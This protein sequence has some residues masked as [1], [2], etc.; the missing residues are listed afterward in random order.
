[1]Q[2]F[3][4]YL[5]LRYK[6]TTPFSNKLNDFINGWF[7]SRKDTFIFT[8]KDNFNSDDIVGT[9]EL[10]KKIYRETNKIHIWNGASD[11]SIFGT[12]ET[13]LKF[14]AWHDF[15]HLNYNLGYS[16]TEESIV[17][18]IQKD[19]L[20]LDWYFEK[21]LID[22]EIRGQAHYFYKN[23][24]FVTNQRMFTISWLE[25]SINALNYKNI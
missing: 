5:Y 13:N 9:F 15:I 16:I 18:D 10:H 20:P 3:N 24:R 23:N 25:N 22:C 6:N 1:M 8:D 2:Q 11:N 17:C 7:E 12:A 4:P 21:S 14:R 19:M